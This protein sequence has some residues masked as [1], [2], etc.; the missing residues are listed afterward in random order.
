LIYFDFIS[1]FNLKLKEQ[2]E[3]TE[4]V[5]V[6]DLIYIFQGIHG[7]Y[8]KFNPESDNFIIDERVNLLFI[9]TVIFY[10]H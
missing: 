3:I 4:D 2:Q 10:I 6:H 9:I 8:I 5:L 1:S 7:R